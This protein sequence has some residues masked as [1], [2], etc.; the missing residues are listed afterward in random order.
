MEMSWPISKHWA[1]WSMLMLTE[2]YG[3]AGMQL[4]GSITHHQSWQHSAQASSA[5]G[6]LG[7]F[8]TA[9]LGIT[10]TQS[11]LAQPEMPP[12]EVIPIGFSPPSP[13]GRVSS[14]F[15]QGAGIRYSGSKSSN[16]GSLELLRGLS[17]LN[18][19]VP[20]RLTQ[21]CAQHA[22]KNS[23]LFLFQWLQEC[24]DKWRAKTSCRYPLET[25]H[26]HHS[27]K[28]HREAHMPQTTIQVDNPF[29]CPETTSSAH[30][31][32]RS[33]IPKSFTQEKYSFKIS[34]VPSFLLLTDCNFPTFLFKFF[35]W[36][37]WFVALSGPSHFGG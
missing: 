1:V 36:L 32:P 3:N 13:G 20:F 5:Q 31:K 8:H 25:H 16:S 23:K 6:A 24:P 18:S 33:A 37:A 12:R 10:L 11:L 30:S 27:Q 4:S 34:F 29:L 35:P 22:S 15:R 21:A 28:K 2:L 19:P 7:H 17:S 9:P 14:A 26:L